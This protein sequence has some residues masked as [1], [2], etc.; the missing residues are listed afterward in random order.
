[1]QV[2]RNVGWLTPWTS[3]CR[4]ACCCEGGACGT[5][6][7]VRSLSKY[8]MAFAA[9]FRFVMKVLQRMAAANHVFW[10][11]GPHHQEVMIRMRLV[12]LLTTPTRMTYMYLQ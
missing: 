5:A 11:V 2:G 3:A 7:A 12:T 1:M 6:R 9:K 10:I 8:F 4:S